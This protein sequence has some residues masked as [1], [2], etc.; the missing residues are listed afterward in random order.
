MTDITSLDEEEKSEHMRYIKRIVA[1]H[2][3]YCSGINDYSQA[4]RDKGVNPYYNRTPGGL[5]LRYHYNMVST[6][7]TPWGEWHFSSVDPR[8]FNAPV[9]EGRLIFSHPLVHARHDPV[10]GSVG[11]VRGILIVDG[12]TA[13]RPIPPV[14]HGGIDYVQAEELLADWWRYY[15]AA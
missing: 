10:L 7:L 2:D 13:P 14:E 15:K 12:L 3:Q 8:H 4:Q 11:L 6:L 1:I 9:F 5:Y